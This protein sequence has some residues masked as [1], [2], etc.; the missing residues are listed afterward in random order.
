[1]TEQLSLPQSGQGSAVLSRTQPVADFSE[2]MLAKTLRFY[3]LTVIRLWNLSGTVCPSL[4]SIRS[5][6]MLCLVLNAEVHPCHTT[7]L[8]AS[9]QAKETSPTKGT[10][11]SPTKENLLIAPSSHDQAAWPIAPLPDHGP[12]IPDQENQRI[13]GIEK[14][15]R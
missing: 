5:P 9:R 15:G 2:N 8:K 6:S 12:A 13:G 10:E 3:K 11:V 14:G 7:L 4:N 1:V